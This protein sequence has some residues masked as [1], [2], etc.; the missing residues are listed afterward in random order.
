MA[1]KAGQ[2]KGL[3]TCSQSEVA[4]ETFLYNLVKILD[5][6]Q[7]VAE[8]EVADQGLG[9]VVG[10]IEEPVHHLGLLRVDNGKVEPDC[11]VLRQRRVTLEDEPGSPYFCQDP[12]ASSP[13]H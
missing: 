11:S 12:L 13:L 1:T 9:G 10:G 2:E 4:G 7:P 5:A 6:V 8:T 3:K